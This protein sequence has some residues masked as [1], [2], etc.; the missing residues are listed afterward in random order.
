M[1]PSFRFSAERWAGLAMLA[2]G[3]LMAGLWLVFTNVH[4]PTS[5]NEDRIIFGGGMFFWGS[6]LGWLPNLL[7]AMGL[8]LL[9]PRLAPPA[10]LGAGWL[11]RQPGRSAGVGPD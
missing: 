2:G 6:L 7:I 9:W 10:P 5:N 1:R 3:V 8:V 4:G 11:W